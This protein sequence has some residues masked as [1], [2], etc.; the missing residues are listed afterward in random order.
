MFQVCILSLQ[1]EI[2][3]LVVAVFEFIFSINLQRV[4]GSWDGYWLT[5]SLIHDG[6]GFSGGVAY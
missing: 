5:E 6:D 2:K 1:L 3:F 4:G